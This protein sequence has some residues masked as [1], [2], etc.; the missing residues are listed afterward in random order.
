M[1]KRATI[2]LLAVCFFLLGASAAQSA[3]PAGIGLILFEPSGLTG[4]MWLRQSTAL[5]AGIGWSA[6]KDHYLHLH[7]D[8]LFWSQRLAAD[9]NLYLDFYLGAGGKV[10]FRDSDN[11]WL[12]LPLGFDIRLRQSPFNF[13]FEVSPI[14]I[15]NRIG[16]GDAMEASFFV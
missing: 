9:K 2:G 12:R 5:A 3:G 6:E 10:I 7:M 11:A 13:F 16:N 14:L 4:K 8:F 1:R 15:Q